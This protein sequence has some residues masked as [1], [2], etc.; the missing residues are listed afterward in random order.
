MRSDDHLCVSFKLETDQSKLTERME[1]AIKK[2][3]VDMVIGN[4]LGNK[5]W[6]L[7][8]FNPTVFGPIKD[9]ELAEDIEKSIVREA[10][11]L[12]QRKFKK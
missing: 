4:Y 9:E 1:A 8:K 5:I 3:G 2:Y 12:K 10:Y 7:V 11:M 6:A